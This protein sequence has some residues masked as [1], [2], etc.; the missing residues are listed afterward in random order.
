[1]GLGAEAVMQWG[2]CAK[3]L[4]LFGHFEEPASPLLVVKL[5]TSGNPARSQPKRHWQF[6][7]HAA[8]GI[9][10]DAKKAVFLAK[11]AV[12]ASTFCKN[13]R[14]PGSRRAFSTK[15]Y[16]DSNQPI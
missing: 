9:H 8:A 3:V 2:Q 16:L 4:N 11:T 1:M 10:V 5:T 14:Q 6:G 15:L 13:E 12:Q 7:V